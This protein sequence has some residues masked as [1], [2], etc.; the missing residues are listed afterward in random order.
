MPNQKAA[1][2]TKKRLAFKFKTF[3]LFFLLFNFVERS[4]LPNQCKAYAAFPAVRGYADFSHL[5]FNKM[6][7]AFSSGQRFKFPDDD[8]VFT[9]ISIRFEY[10]DPIISYANENGE[11]CEARGFYLS[12]LTHA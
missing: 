10:N 12:D 6:A 4:A 3:A 9:F 11:E 8:N 1:A 7:I 5:N 2:V